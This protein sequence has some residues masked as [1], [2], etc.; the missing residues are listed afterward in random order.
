M[1]LLRHKLDRYDGDMTNIIRRNE[2]TSNF[3][4]NSNP[5]Y[6]NGTGNGSEEEPGTPWLLPYYMNLVFSEL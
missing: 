5:Y 1:N 3:K 2:R 4:W 6:E